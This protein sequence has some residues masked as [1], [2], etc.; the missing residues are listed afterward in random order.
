LDKKP[1]GE[2]GGARNNAALL[3]GMSPSQITHK[4]R[5]KRDELHECNGLRIGLHGQQSGLYP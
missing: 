3:P 1:F 5:Q 4:R 2:H